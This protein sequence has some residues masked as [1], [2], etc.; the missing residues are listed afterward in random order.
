[1]LLE[2][3]RRTLT[4]ASTPDHL[5]PELQHTASSSSSVREHQQRREA[6]AT[7][8]EQHQHQQP[9]SVGDPMEHIQPAASWDTRAFVRKP[10]DTAVSRPPS[11]SSLRSDK[12]PHH[13]DH[14]E[15]Q[16]T[17]KG[18]TA[19]AAAPASLHR[20]PPPRFTIRP[21]SRSFNGKFTLRQ[22]SPPPLVPEWHGSTA[23]V[24]SS[25]AFDFSSSSNFGTRDMP[26]TSDSDASMD[27]EVASLTSGRRLGNGA[28]GLLR[29]ANAP[30]RPRSGE[31]RIRDAESAVAL[32]A[33]LSP[34]TREAEPPSRNEER[35]VHKQQQQQQQREQQ[36]GGGA[37]SKWGSNST[38]VV[39]EGDSDAAA[40]GWGGSEPAA[41]RQRRCQTPQV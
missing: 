20:E 41:K 9:C 4:H 15:E 30:S 26:C 23:A 35:Q 2:Q 36:G 5:S 19:A 25:S 27:A 21:P 34:S 14:H 7:Q 24:C 1:M 3:E 11:S 33:L 12:Q 13:H 17:L 40:G 16:T 39:G 18:E 38:A 31:P 29:M 6:P 37:T 22:C 10:L 32:F 8:Q 28:E